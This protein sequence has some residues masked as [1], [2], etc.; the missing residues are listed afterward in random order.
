MNASADKAVMVTNAR[1]ASPFVIVVDHASNRLPDRFGTLGL[2]MT[3]RLSHVA[4]DPGALAV[5]R[6]LSDQLDA[7]MVQATF[8]RLVIDPNRGLDAPDLI[9]TLSERTRIPGNENLSPEERQYRIDHYH[10]PYHAAIETLL[11]AR[12]HAGLS[13]ILVC[14]H[15]FTPVYHGVQRPWPIG[16]VVPHDEG[17]TAAFRDALLALEPDLRVGWNE[18]YAASM[19][20]TLTLERHGNARGIDAIMIELRHDEILTLDGVALW[21]ER[22]AEGLMT[23]LLTRQ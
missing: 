21:T 18:P 23:A 1:G 5:S 4:W 13:S 20:L 8:S 9:W 11:E 15:S 22:I 6:A 10:R 12:R 2:T 17:F 7:P 3:E 19:G 14:M 16:L